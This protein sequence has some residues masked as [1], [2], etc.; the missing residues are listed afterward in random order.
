MQLYFSLSLFFF[1]LNI[2]VY[3]VGNVSGNQFLIDAAIPGTGDGSLENDL[4]GQISALNNSGGGFNPTLIFGPFDVAIQILENIF[5][6]GFIV[7]M[8]QSLCFNCNDLIYFTAPFQVML[9]FL[10]IIAVVGLLRGINI[11]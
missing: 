9:L 7:D 8:I 4:K 6:G 1:C 3:F 5:A 2:G 11:I 10:N